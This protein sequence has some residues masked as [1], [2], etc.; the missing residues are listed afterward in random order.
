MPVPEALRG[1]SCDRDFWAGF[2]G[3]GD[4]GDARRGELRASFPVAGGYG[5]VLDLDLTHGEH[6][7]GLRQPAA[8]E[9]VHLAGTGPGR[10]RPG[11][12]RWSELDIVGRVLALDD[13]TL[14]HPGLPVA[15][16]SRFAPVTAGDDPASVGALLEAAY[17][18]LRREVTPPA[19]VTPEQAPLP[20]FTGTEW[21]PQPAGPSAQVLSEGQIAEY[22]GLGGG[23]G[24]QVRGT[25]R[26]PAAGLAEMVRLARARLDRLRDAPWYDPATVP[27]LA[28]RIAATGDLALVGWLADVLDRGGCDHPTV[29]DALTGPVVPVEACWMVETLAGTEPGAL[30]GRHFGARAAGTAPPARD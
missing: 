2:L 13:P 11:A 14:P 22:L 30:I 4:P 10:P 1:L 28:R 18:S 17:R 12:L 23:D 9:P 29:M 24:G 3:G 19:A 25:A 27:R 8:T 6:A 20:L 7:L 26:F 16:L 5:L 15:L 21:W